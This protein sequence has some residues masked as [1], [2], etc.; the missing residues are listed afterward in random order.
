[1]CLLLF[2]FALLVCNAAA[3]LASRLARSLAFAASALLSAFAKV[4]GLECFNSLH[5][6]PAFV[7]LI[8]IHH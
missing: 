8:C 1:M 6:D 5:I 4:A 7:N 2:V 3:G